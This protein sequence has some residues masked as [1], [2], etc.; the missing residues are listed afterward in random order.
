MVDNYGRS[1][2]GRVK[3]SIIV[4]GIPGWFYMVRPISCGP[5]AINELRHVIPGQRPLA[6]LKAAEEA[7]TGAEH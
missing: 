1:D 6:V 5:G 2:L 7:L 4:C 3:G